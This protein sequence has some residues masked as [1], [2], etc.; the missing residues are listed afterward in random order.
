FP[1]NLFSR[2]PGLPLLQHRQLLLTTPSPSPTAP[3]LGRFHHGVPVVL[4]RL[5]DLSKSEVG[6]DKGC[7]LLALHLS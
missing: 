6:H 7:S 2:Y 1:A 5:Y 3:I 4:P